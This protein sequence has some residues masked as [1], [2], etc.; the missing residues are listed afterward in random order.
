MVSTVLSLLASVTVTPSVGAGVPN[1]TLNGTDRVGP[2]ETLEG[3]PI[4]PGGSTVT[5]A[6]ASGM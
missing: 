1:V 5:L 3:S 6:V 4:A 2:T